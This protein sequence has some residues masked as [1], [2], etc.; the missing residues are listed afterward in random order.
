MSREQIY[1][2]IGNMPDQA[3][4]YTIVLVKEGEHD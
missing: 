1:S 2:D 4:Y 3:S